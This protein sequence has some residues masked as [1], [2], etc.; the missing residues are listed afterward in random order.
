MDGMRLDAMCTLVIDGL[1]GEM[2]A[3]VSNPASAHQP[4]FILSFSSALAFW[5][6]LVRCSCVRVSNP[7]G[8]TACAMQD[9]YSHNPLRLSGGAT[10]FERSHMD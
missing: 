5:Q 6:H 3:S 7:T 8:C 4:S 1:V 10:L 9:H 2:A